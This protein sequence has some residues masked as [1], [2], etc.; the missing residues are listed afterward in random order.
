MI[1]NLH[2][3]MWL[4][5]AVFTIIVFYLQLIY[6]D[7]DVGDGFEPAGS[8]DY[9]ADQPTQA[10]PDQPVVAGFSSAGPE[11]RELQLGRSPPATGAGCL[12]RPAAAGMTGFVY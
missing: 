5:L 8:A 3:I 1:C 2:V 4:T 9:S 11:P 6:S 12:L 10:V 7:E